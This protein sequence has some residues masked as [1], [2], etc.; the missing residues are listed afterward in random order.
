M[1]RAT[2]QL[3]R[4]D[5]VQGIYLLH[6]ASR[7]WA[8]LCLAN[9]VRWS[10][11]TR[12]KID[13]KEYKKTNQRPRGN[14]F[15]GNDFDSVPSIH[16]SNILSTLQTLRIILVLSLASP[17][18][19]ASRRARIPLTTTLTPRTYSATARARRCRR[20]GTGRSRGRL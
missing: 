8:L 19:L 12:Q 9:V 20:I 7:H 4:E 2:V 11:G 10:K 5:M 17:P 14:G 6:T 16:S 18:S 15:F 13:H 1:I 3:A